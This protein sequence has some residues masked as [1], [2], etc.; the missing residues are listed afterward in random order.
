MLKALKTKKSGFSIVEV[1]VAAVIFALATAGLFTAVSLTRPQATETYED[2]EGLFLA[3]MKIDEVTSLV[4]AGQWDNATSP[5]AP[6]TYSENY[7][8]VYLEWTITDNPI[9]GGRDV[10]MSIEI[11]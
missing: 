9:T 6:G 8:G 5:I 7:N 3:R 10:S 1:I 4:A 2:V 11:Q